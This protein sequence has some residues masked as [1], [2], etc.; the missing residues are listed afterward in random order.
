MIL[1]NWLNNGWLAEHRASSQ[2]I[3]ALLAVA[4]RDLSDCRTSGLSPDWQLNIA[5]NA[6][7]QT[8]TAALAASGYRAPCEKLIITGLFNLLLI[9]S[10]LMPT[11]LLCLINFERKGISAVMIMPV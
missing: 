11:W 3:A 2:E 1:Q 8:A 10:R 7:L 4:D 5:Y 6:A 9:L